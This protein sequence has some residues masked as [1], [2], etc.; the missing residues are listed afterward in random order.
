MTY[1]IRAGEMLL[2]GYKSFGSSS[3]FCM[4]ALF[5]WYILHAGWVTLFC[6]SHF[7][8]KPIPPSL[9][10]LLRNNHSSRCSGSAPSSSRTPQWSFTALPLCCGSHRGHVCV[11]INRI[12]G[13][14][15]V[16]SSALIRRVWHGVQVEFVSARHPAAHWQAS[17]T[18]QEVI[19]SS[20]KV[21]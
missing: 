13:T 6:R 21:I 12:Y 15:V 4:T 19:F 14:I 18:G 20:E 5:I 16:K 9:W 11:D 1:C 10:G 7:G 2:I 3:Q 8:I 17:L